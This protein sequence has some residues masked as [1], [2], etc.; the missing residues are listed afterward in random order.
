MYAIYFFIQETSSALQDIKLIDIECDCCNT[1]EFNIGISTVV[2]IYGGDTLIVARY[3]FFFSDHFFV[4]DN[5]CMH[6]INSN[7]IL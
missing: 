3:F 6:H 5:L 2:I 1:I 4:V 7:S